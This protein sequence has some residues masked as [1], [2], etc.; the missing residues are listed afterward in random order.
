MVA[1]LKDRELMDMT[2]WADAALQAVARMK[3][4]N[5]ILDEIRAQSSDKEMR[6]IL[7]GGGGDAEG[8]GGQAEGDE[9]F[10]LTSSSAV[11]S[12]SLSG[13]SMI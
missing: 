13:A 4:M 8:D 5:L 3:A 9:R 11:V 2:V 12:A 1:S 10:R 6:L 7:D